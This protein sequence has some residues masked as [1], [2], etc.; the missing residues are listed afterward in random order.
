MG[1]Q[2]YWLKPGKPP[3][4]HSEPLRCSTGKIEN[5]YFRVQI[6]PASG[7]LRSVFD[8]EHKR[9]VLAA[10]GKG[11]QVQILEDFGDSEGFLRSADGVAE[12]NQWT[13]GG[14]W[15]VASDPRIVLLE[16][17][18]VRA[19]VEIRR[20]FGLARFKQ[21]IALYSGIPRID[22][23]LAVD[24]RG[25]NKMVKVGF[26]LAVS[27]PE[28]TYEIPYGAIRRPSKGEEQAAQNWVDV[29]DSSYGVSLLNDGRYGFDVTPNTIRMSILRSPTKPVLS[30]DEAGTHEVKYV[31]YPHLGGWQS[32]GVVRRGYELNNPL[33]AVVDR[34]HSGDLPAACSFVKVEPEN[35]VMTVLKKAED[36]EQLI[37]RCYEAEGKACTVRIA[38]AAP[39]AAD[40]VHGAD[41]LENDEVELPV[42]NRG[43]VADAPAYSIN[44]YK[45]YC[46]N[47]P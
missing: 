40:A 39:I 14:L 20:K 22:F 15:N 10:E 41:L 3:D 38:L 47:G 30:T 21:R 16:R 6:D 43:F 33:I 27:S 23:D 9:E 5:A 44:T 17:G 42:K 8:K 18:P 7:C 34:P 36:S 35:L 45:L 4:S 32:A 28:A 24:W 13:G 29:S 31:L 11:N 26:P 12:H 37:M 46:E 2:C 25:S 1:Y 19:V